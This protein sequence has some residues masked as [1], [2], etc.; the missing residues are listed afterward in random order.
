MKNLTLLFLLTISFTLS[1]Q[2]KS[3]IMTHTDGSVS[4]SE[5]SKSDNS[6]SKFYIVLRSDKKL[7]TQFAEVKYY[8]DYAVAN[9]NGENIF[10]G[11]D[12]AMADKYKNIVS[13][14]GIATY[15]KFQL[16]GIKFGPDHVTSAKAA[17]GSIGGPGSDPAGKLCVAGGPGS[18]ECTA[19][20]PNGCS[21]KCNSGYYACC[22]LFCNC[23]KE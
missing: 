12:G 14:A 21:V 22:N 17:G 23:V 11:N 4:I 8:D 18:S 3:L 20:A 19:N 13:G 9:I 7:K 5:W 6:F 16:K 15:T 1:A 10:F 2:N